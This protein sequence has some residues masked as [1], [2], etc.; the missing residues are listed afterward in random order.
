V[1]TDGPEY[2]TT[3]LVLPKCD[4]PPAVIATPSVLPVPRIIMHMIAVLDVQPDASHPVFPIV[5]AIVNI[6]C[7][8][9]DPWRVI[10]VD[11]VAGTFGYLTTNGDIAGVSVVNILVPV[12]L[13]LA[14]VN[15]T[16]A[17]VV[18]DAIA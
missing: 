11:P 6:H 14:I 1:L 7:L 4:P 16:L 13:N 12:D 8:K 2:E 18:E 15:D 10:L 5:D 9:L 3:E 17:V